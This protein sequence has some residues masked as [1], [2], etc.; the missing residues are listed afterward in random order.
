MSAIDQTEK[1]ADRIRSELLST[2]GELDRRRKR[3]TSVRY[4]VTSHLPFVVAG[5]AVLAGAAGIA[6]WVG[7]VRGHS[8]KS[9]NLRARVEAFMR[10]WEHP[11]RVATR[12][13]DKPLP[14][15]LGKK[16]LLIFAGAMAA[17]L[18]RVSAE[19][20]LPAGS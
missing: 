11:N 6:I 14:M 16:L 15:E 7:R 2:L 3:A 13:K 5:A 1:T 17:R 4:Q 20:L 19:K 9:I 12:A 18:A 10:A 8:R